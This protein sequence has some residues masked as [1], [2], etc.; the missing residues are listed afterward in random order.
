MFSFP[1]GGFIGDYTVGI[2]EVFRVLI[3]DIAEPLTT[4]TDSVRRHRVNIIGPAIDSF[5]H[6][7]DYAEIERLLK[8]LNVSVNTVF[9]Q[10][11]YVGQ[12]RRVADAELNI[13][14]RDT[15]LPA[16]EQLLQRFG[17]PYHYSI[18]FGLKGTVNWLTSVAEKLDLDLKSDVVVRELKKYGHTLTELTSWW[19][20]HE[21]LKVAIS[22]PYGQTFRY[23][24]QFTGS[25]E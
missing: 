2:K 17:M 24:P 10:E 16:A 3:D 18:S 22:C 23:N 11:T 25:G 14:T 8:L 7:S 15:A 19:Q 20:R 5:N 12:L 9:T 4:E 1:G 21:H 6:I 13:V